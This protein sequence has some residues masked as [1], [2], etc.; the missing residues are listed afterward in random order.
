M[1]VLTVPI[2]VCYVAVL[3]VICVYGLHR[4]WMVGVF[5]TRHRRAPFDAGPSQRFEQL[6]RVTVQLPMFNERHVAVRVIE[7]ACGIDYPRDRLEVQVLDDSTDESAGIARRCCDRLAEA[8]HNVRYIHRHNREGFKAGALADGLRFADGE[9]IAVFDADFVPPPDVLRRSIH[10]FTDGGLGMVQLRWTHLNRHDSLLTEIQAM[11]LDGHFVIEQTARASSGRWFNFNGTAGVWRRSCIEDAGGWQHDTLTEDTD[12]SYRAQMKGWRF[13]YLPAV[14]CPAEVPPTVGAFL[15]QQHRW[16][17]GL[18]QTAIKLLPRIMTSRA[19]LGIK[20]EAWFHL[21]SPLVHVAILLLAVL[22]A[23]LLLLPWHSGS[24]DINPNVAFGVGGMLL[25]L[26]TLAACTF[27]VA[28][29]WAQGT[30]LWHTVARLPALMSL[31][32]GI[33]LTNTRAVAEALLGRRTPFLR[34]PKYNGA[35][36]SA[37]DPLL[38]RRRWAPLGAMELVL[39]SVML[40]CLV[41]ALVQPETLIGAPFVLLFACG[42]L[43]IGLPGFRRSWEGGA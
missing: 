27:Y 19:P 3:A 39:G 22:V 10:H 43:G 2:L 25:V 16:N 21:T 7:A 15:T 34:T 13:L 38:R 35:A 5:L 33:S 24:F 40:V 37:P 11:F 12:L 6:P 20:I 14:A 4:Y 31:G 8:G 42:Y 18:I 36:S 26:G 32:I 1:N 28:S 29:Q 30:S 17:K 23:P 41:A 9:F